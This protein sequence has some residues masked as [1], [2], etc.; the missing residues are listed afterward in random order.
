SVAAGDDV[1]DWRSVE[2]VPPP[3]L[4]GVAIRLVPPD[5][6]G[7]APQVLAAGRTLIRG[8]EGTR[9]EV[10]ATATKPIA[11]AVLRR[12][13][14]ASGD[15]VPIDSTGLKLSARFTLADSVPFWFELRDTEGFRSQEAVRYESR[16]V[17]DEAPRVVIDEPT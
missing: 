6:T 11:S 8:V 2:V 12:G 1:T 14:G 4:Q 7:L 16:A 3:A 5:Y 10:E 9:V 13:E 17:K 15:K